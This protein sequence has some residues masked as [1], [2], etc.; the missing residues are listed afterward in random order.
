MEGGARE[1]GRLREFNAD[2][3]GVD[4]WY[5]DSWNQVRSIGGDGF[6]WVPL[7]RLQMGEDNSKR[8][9]VEMNKL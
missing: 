1:V 3:D 6:T 7:L 9:K 5:E 4:C 2:D 8:R